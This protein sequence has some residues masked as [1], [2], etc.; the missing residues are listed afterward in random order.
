M[1][2]LDELNLERYDQNWYIFSTRNKYASFMPGPKRMHSNRP[3][4]WWRKIVKEDL[5]LDITQYSLKKLAGN[6]MVRLLYNERVNDLIKFPQRQM[7]H[8]TSEMTEV[9]VDEHISY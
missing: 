2:L 4:T 3:T 8:T 5:K 9:Y 7:G 1:N 6:D